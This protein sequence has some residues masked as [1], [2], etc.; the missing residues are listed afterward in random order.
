MAFVV[1]KYR[2]K[3]TENRKDVYR[4]LDNELERLTFFK[5]K[6]VACEVRHLHARTK[7]SRDRRARR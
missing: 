6:D 5:V 2:L 7:E 3:N 1:M 4:L